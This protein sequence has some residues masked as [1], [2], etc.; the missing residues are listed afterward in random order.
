MPPAPHVHL[1]MNA[2]LL[3]LVVSEE[4]VPSVPVEANPQAFVVEDSA[5]SSRYGRPLKRSIVFSPPAQE[6]QRRRTCARSVP[7]SPHLEGPAQEDVQLLFDL[8]QQSEPR[9]V[10]ARDDGAALAEFQWHVSTGHFPAARQLI[11]PGPRPSSCD[12]I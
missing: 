5:P 12:E 3:G 9:R 10:E 7:A 1:A 11:H 8:H 6:A 2:A 4:V